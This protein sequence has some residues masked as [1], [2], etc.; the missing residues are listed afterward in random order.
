M[1]CVQGN[2]RDVLGVY[3]RGTPGHR[4][5]MGLAITTLMDM[6]VRARHRIEVRGHENYTHLP[7]TLVV[8]NH[9]RDTDG[10][11]VA[12]L[13][14]Q[15]RGLRFHGAI[16]SFV[17]REDLFTPG[18]LE[19][20]LTHYP[21]AI[22][23]LA[24]RINIRPLIEGA[25]AYPIRRIQERTLGEV[26]TDVL[27]VF[28]NLPLEEVLRPSWAERF[29]AALGCA[30]AALTTCDALDQRCHQLTAMRGGYRRLRTA[31][32]RRLKPFERAVIE[33]QLARFIALLE[34]GE[35]VI[36]KPEG[37]VSPDGSLS[38]PRA[39]LYMLINRVAAPLCVLPVSI[40]YDCMDSEARVFLCVGRQIS[41]LRGLPKTEIETRIMEDVRSGRTVTCSQLAA[42]R[43][44]CLARAGR[45]RLCESELREFVTAAAHACN[46]AGLYVDPR[47]HEHT[48]CS[49]RVSGWLQ[50]CLRRGLLYTEGSDGYRTGQLDLPPSWLINPKVS[51]L[52]YLD[53]ELQTI[54]GG[55]LPALSALDP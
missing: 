26:L 13:L 37:V 5:W 35:P 51:L 17:A 40:T 32:F 8:A 3:H 31:C 33:A 28:G 2:Y 10:P 16:A 44:L 27:R 41:R 36:L 42:H 30:P 11:I 9:C 14:M 49:R 48:Q 43:L 52:R 54:L 4:D 1:S 22:R 18:F 23:R 20:Y 15:R 29:G 7:H 25:G 46:A 12:S 21:T 19:R 34:A 50:Y 6:A 53:N 45:H 55:P 24:G 47:L 38:R 39:A